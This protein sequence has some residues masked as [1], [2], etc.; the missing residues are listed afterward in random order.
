MGDV[1]KAKQLAVRLKTDKE[2]YDDCSKIAKTR[3]NEC[4][5]EKEYTYCMNKV[6]GKVISQ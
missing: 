2:F 6:I 5:G 4:F 1:K 3:Y